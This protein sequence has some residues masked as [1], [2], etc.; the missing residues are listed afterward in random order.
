MW[1]GHLALSSESGLACTVKR[2]AYL[3]HVQGCGGGEEGK[4]DE[5]RDLEQMRMPVHACSTP[6]ELLGHS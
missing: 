2:S 3:F 5:G 1:G 4:R 6:E